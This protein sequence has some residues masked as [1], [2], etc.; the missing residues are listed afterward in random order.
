MQTVL[1]SFL[2]FIIL[3]ITIPTTFIHASSYILKEKLPVDSRPHPKTIKVWNHIQKMPDPLALDHNENK[4]NAPVPWN[5]LQ[6]GDILLG[7]G[8]RKN[9]IPYGFFRHAGIWHQGK[10]MILSAMP[11]E[12]VCFQSPAL[13]N[14]HFPRL[15]FLTVPTVDGQTKEMIT[16]YGERQM[17]KPYVFSKKYTNRSWYCSKIPWSCYKGQGIDLDYYGLFLVTPDSLYYSP[18]TKS[19]YKRL[20]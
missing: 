1:R 3:N 20:G 9:S 6:W 4:H 10:K 12:G 7:K 5:L 11:N 14:N 15:E 2:V 16:K 8:K 18:H 13:W 19:I 17:G